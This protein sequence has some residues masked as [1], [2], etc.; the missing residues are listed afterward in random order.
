MCS[1]TGLEITAFAGSFSFSVIRRVIEV[2]RRFQLACEQTARRAMDNVLVFVCR[3]GADSPVD[4][5]NLTAA[6]ISAIRGITGPAIA[7]R[8]DMCVFRD[9]D[10]HTPVG[11]RF[12]SSFALPAS[13]V[14]A[15]RQITILWH[16]D[17]L[18]FVTI[19]FEA[20]DARPTGAN[21]GV[22]QISVDRHIDLQTGP[23][24]GPVSAITLPVVAVLEISIVRDRDCDAVLYDSLESSLAA[25]ATAIAV[26]FEVGV[27]WNV[28]LQTRTL[29]FPETRITAPAST[30][31]IRS[32]VLR[33]QLV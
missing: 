31:G 13:A 27:I 28:Y 33:H 4:S 19:R 8:T 5:A 23:V 17:R 24:L 9:D 2:E 32:C 18:A 11:V 12:K 25:P 14:R 3:D 21:V 10:G 29:L 30:I 22:P 7:R 15:L 16:I 20:I 26:I 6:S 1:R